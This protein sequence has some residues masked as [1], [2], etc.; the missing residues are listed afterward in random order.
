M[1]REKDLGKKVFSR[2]D[3]MKISGLCGG[4]L[5]LGEWSNMPLS[6]AE[7]AYPS[8]KITWIVPHQAGGGEDLI[9]RG[10]IPFMEKYLKAV[11]KNPGR[12]GMLIKNLPGGGTM[13]GINTVIKA[14]P[15]GYTIGSGSETLFTKHVLGELGFDLFSINFIGRLASAHKVLVTNKKSN[16]NTWDDVVKASKQ[17]PVKIGIGGFGASNHVAAIL[18]IGASQLAARMIMLEG[19][20]QVNALLIR[21]DFPL[22]MHSWDSIRPLIEANELRP[23]VTFSEAIKYPGVPNVKEIGFPELNDIL[24]SQRY[25]IAPAK[26]P[27]NVK[28]IL[29]DSMKKAVADKEFI[30]WKEKANMSYDPV[31]GSEFEALIKNIL[32]FYKSKEKILREYLVEK[33]S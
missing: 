1:R 10:L 21:G 22:A 7:E 18:F 17:A 13:R 2:R 19:T 33:K 11:S 14:R 3:F 23:I 12:V 29:E 26:L 30:A 20:P 6:F 5:A 9:P 31:I 24:D 28:T 25:V 32:T 8:E 27:G 16:L 4:V 15:D